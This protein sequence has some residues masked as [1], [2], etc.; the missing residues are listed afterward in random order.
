MKRILFK[1]KGTHLGSE[2]QV[3]NWFDSSGSSQVRH[4]QQ[5]L[6]TWPPCT[7]IPTAKGC[8]PLVTMQCPAKPWGGDLGRAEGTSHKGE[9]AAGELRMASDQGLA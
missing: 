1:E 3:S 4:I 5:E 9:S 8:N 7:I 6:L 2:K